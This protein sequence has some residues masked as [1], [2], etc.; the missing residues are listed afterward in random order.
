MQIATLLAVYM[1]WSFA[2]IQGCGWGW[3][4]VIWLYSL[5]TYIPL[6]FLKFAI[7]YILGGKA[8]NNL[9]DKKVYISSLKIAFVRGNLNFSHIFGTLNF[10]I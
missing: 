1:S 3:A 7:R 9:L 4:G 10:D 6:D 5:V 2:K 8:W